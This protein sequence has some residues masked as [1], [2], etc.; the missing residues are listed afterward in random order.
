[1]PL[2]ALLLRLLL[3][4]ALIFNGAGSAV[5]S[6]HAAGGGAMASLPFLEGQFLPAG[7]PHCADSDMPSPSGSRDDARGVA[8]GPVPGPGD[9][10]APDCCDVSACACTCAHACASVIPAV[11]QLPLSIAR[12]RGVGIGAFGHAAPALPHL[13]RPPIA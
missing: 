7:L 2:P 12:D 10:P 3:S 13:I 6:V 4:M 5:A 11:A 1:M 9:H 8:P